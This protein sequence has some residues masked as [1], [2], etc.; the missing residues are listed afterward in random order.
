MIIAACSFVLWVTY[1]SMGPT[2]DVV[3]RVDIP[4]SAHQTLQICE[5]DANKAR[6]QAFKGGTTKGLIITHKCLPDTIDPRK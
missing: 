3:Q 6:L 4:G 1:F 2:G 5:D